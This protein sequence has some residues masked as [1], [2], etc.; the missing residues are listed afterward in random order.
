MDDDVPGSV[1]PVVELG[2][3][4]VFSAEVHPVADTVPTGGFAGVLAE[5]TSA[6]W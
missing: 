3:E 4:V 5:R 6:G 1:G 2:V